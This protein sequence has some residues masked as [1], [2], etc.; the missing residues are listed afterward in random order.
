MKSEDATLP[1]QSGSDAV[2]R[3]DF[4]RVGAAAGIGSLAAEPSAAAAQNNRATAAAAGEGLP[5]GETLRIYEGTAAGAVVEQLRTAGVR[6]IFHTNTSGFSPLWDAIYAAGDVQIVMVTH[7]GQGVAAAHGYALAKKTLGFFVGSGAGIGNAMSNLYCAWKDR[8]PLLVTFS[9]GDIESQGLDGAETWDGNLKPTEPFAMWT[10]SFLTDEMTDILRRAIKYAYGPPSGPVTLDWGNANQAARV[11]APIFPI[12]LARAR[13]VF[14][15]KADHIEKAARWLAEAQHPLF[16]AGPEVT[17]EGAVEDLQALAEK[18]SVP[19]TVLGW[20][21]ELYANFPT[22][23]PLY[24][25][26]Y[27]ALRNPRNIDLVVNFGEK[28]AIRHPVGTPTVHIAHNP[29]MLGKMFPA[30]LPIA[31]E[32]RSAIRDLSDALDSVL[33][34][35][36]IARIRTERLAEVS[37]Y[38]SQLRES[39][40]LALRGRFDS[41]PVSWERLGYELEQVLDKDAVIVPEVGTQSQ[42]LLGQLTFGPRNKLRIGR[43]TGSALGWGVGA[44]FGVNLALPERQVVAIQGDG[45]FLFGQSETLWTISRYEA[46]MLIV[47]MNNGVYNDSRARNMATGGLL[48]EAGKDLTGH[49]GN[50]DVDYTKIA[51][52]YGLKGE[53]VTTPAEL[54]PALQRSLRSMRDGKAVVLDVKI[55]PDGAPLSEGTWYQR[56]SIADIRRKRQNA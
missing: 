32:V 10:G 52:A 42:K 2:S 8:T 40:R 54:A 13:H 16:I 24:L 44:A 37:K 47:I 7:E 6:T 39:R 53:K 9:H 18:L 34:S 45:G 5:K 33:T 43:T 46:P 17:E 20:P 19:V 12:D 56:Y 23:H 41:N 49:L 21:N 4:L 22:D 36:R 1:G 35:D 51:E 11:K 29:D 26:E 3:R 14:R 50:P 38:S 30:D 25:G 27:D 15:A 31:S 28:F 48:F 55:K